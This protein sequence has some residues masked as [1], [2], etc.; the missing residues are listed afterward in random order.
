MCRPYEKTVPNPVRREQN[1]RKWKEDE[2][3]PLIPRETREISKANPPKAR[4]YAIAANSEQ[5]WGP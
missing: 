1:T 2:G 3:V 5:I 4:V